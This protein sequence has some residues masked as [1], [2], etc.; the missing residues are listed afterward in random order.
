MQMGEPRMSMLLKMKKVIKLVEENIDRLFD[1]FSD[2][3]LKA[4]S[5]KCHML[6]NTDEGFK[7]K[8]K[9]YT[10]TK[11]SNLNVLG[12]QCNNKFDFDRYV[13]SF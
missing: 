4:N 11:S 10:I 12:I 6:I 1:W 2:N 3:F 5:D 9:N 8:I 7:L 13:T